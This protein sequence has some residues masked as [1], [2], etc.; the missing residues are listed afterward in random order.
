MLYAIL[1]PTAGNGQGKKTALLIEDALKKKNISAVFLETKGP[2]HATA[3]AQKAAAEG[4]DTVLAI[5]GDGTALEVAR[6]LMGT[7]CALGIIPAGTGNDFRKTLGIPKDPLQALETVLQKPALPTDTGLLNGSTFLNEIGTGFDVAVLDYAEKAKKHCRGILPYLWG[8]LCALFRFRPI[9][10]NVRI[11]D[12]PQ[13]QKELFVIAAAN[14][15]IIGGGMAVAPDAKADDGLMDIVM[16]DS[17]RRYKLPLRLLGLLQGKILTFPETHF[18]R[19]KKI[20]FS[21]PGMRLNVDGE[22]I[23]ADKACALLQPGQLN[24]HR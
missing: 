19:A 8:V 24:I 21:S 3:L 2:G 11:D 6:G 12:G 7:G 16:V 15:G 20:E 13:E 9:P 14:G 23:A 18:V 17:I 22:I 5:G 4:A 1:N 10:V